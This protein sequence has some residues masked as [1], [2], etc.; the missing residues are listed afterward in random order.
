[1]KSFTIMT[2]LCSALAIATAIPA[3]NDVSLFDEKKS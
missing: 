2:T 3:P 1:M